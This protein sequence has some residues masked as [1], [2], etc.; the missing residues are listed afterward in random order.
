M[1]LLL[2]VSL[3]V[4]AASGCRSR[5]KAEPPKSVPPAV[6]ETAPSAPE[7][8]V[9]TPD[10]D[11]VNPTADTGD[12][13][14]EDIREADRMAR[15]RGWIRDAFFAFDAS[16]LDG[17]AESALTQSGTWLRQHPELRIRIEGHCDE[18]GTEQYNLALGQRRA[19]S[20]KHYLTD[21]GVKPAQL[22]AISFGAEK[23]RAT[24]HDEAAWQQNRRARLALSGRR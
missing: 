13:L 23:P 8:A 3:C 16:T 5:P 12:V 17:D 6:A 14:S 11:F 18:R 24:G 22:A 21:L 7:V 10:R 9:E 1:L 20:A 15:E 2:I 19:D 4:V